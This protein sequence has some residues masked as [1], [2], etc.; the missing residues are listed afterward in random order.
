MTESMSRRPVPAAM[1]TEYAIDKLYGTTN[2]ALR[3]CGRSRVAARSGHPDAP[4]RVR[5]NPTAVAIRS[6]G[7]VVSVFYPAFRI[8]LAP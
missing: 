1:L 5:G 6:R 2:S 7:P 3:C 4:S 8:R